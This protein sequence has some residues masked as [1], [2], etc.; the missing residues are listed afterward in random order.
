MAKTI[1]DCRTRQDILNNYGA[2]RWVG[3]GCLV[4]GVARNQSTVFCY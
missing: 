1:M 3:G 2:I 4:V